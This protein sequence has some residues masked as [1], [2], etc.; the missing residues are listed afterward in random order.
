MRNILLVY[1]S[2][3]NKVIEIAHFVKFTNRVMPFP[4][5]KISGAK[6][7]S[8]NCGKIRHGVIDP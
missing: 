7:E 5:I 1:G 2:Y 6:D 3:F 4:L 8:L